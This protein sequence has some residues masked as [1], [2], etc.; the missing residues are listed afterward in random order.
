V[1]LKTVHTAPWPHCPNKNVF[2]NRLN[3]LYDRPHSLRLGGNSLEC[4][5]LLHVNHTRV[6]VDVKQL[7]N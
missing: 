2:S 1:Q 6:Y 7:L 4:C 3:L 5:C